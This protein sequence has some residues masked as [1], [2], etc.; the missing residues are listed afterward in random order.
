MADIAARVIE[1][2]DDQFGAIV[3]RDTRF[4]DDLGA[5]SL[6]CVELVMELEAEFDLVVQ[7]EDVEALV[8]V[9]EMVDYVKRR[10]GV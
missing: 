6:D 5:D 9:G 3:T 2:V 10:V 1:I 7:D 4:V 8:T